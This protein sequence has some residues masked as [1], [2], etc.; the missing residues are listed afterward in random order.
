MARDENNDGLL[1]ILAPQAMT[2]PSTTAER[3]R[4]FARLKNKPICSRVGLAAVVFIRA[5]RSWMARA[6]RPLNI[7][8]AAARAFCAM[9]RYSR[10][11]DALYET[12]A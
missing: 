4:S 11:L 6:F 2:E 8:T 7:L 1:V 3:L 5:W 9:W 12:P 10:N